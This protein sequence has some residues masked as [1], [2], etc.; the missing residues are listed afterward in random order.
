MDIISTTVNST[1]P[2]KGWIE[3][4]KYD[5][6]AATEERLLIDVERINKRLDQETNWRQ[7]ITNS[8]ANLLKAVNDTLGDLYSNG[9]VD[10][11]DA[12]HFEHL[13]SWFESGELKYP[14]ETEHKIQID[15]SQEWT[16]KMVVKAPSYMSKEDLMDYIRDEVESADYESDNMPS[17]IAGDLISVTNITDTR[18]STT[19]E[20]W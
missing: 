19:V 1:F 16:I 13:Q 3:R 4:A 15:V 14:F 9:V 11:D 7:S 8:Y 5:E 12:H 17:E 2:F 6:L 20:L 10:D 18:K